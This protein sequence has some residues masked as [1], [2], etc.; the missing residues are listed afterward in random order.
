MK[1]IQTFIIAAFI[2]ALA[3]VPVSRANAATTN[4]PTLDHFK[5][6]AIQQANPVNDFVL[7]QDQFDI[8]DATKEQALVR[9]P[10]F[11]CNPTVK[12][13]RSVTGG[14][15]TTTP[16]T[17]PD[18]HLKMYLMVSEPAGPT[19]AVIVSNQFND[20]QHPQTLAVFRPIILG[21]PTRKLPH[22]PPQ[23]LDH[24]KCYLAQGEPMGKTVALRD[25]F[26][27]RQTEVVSVLS[28]VLFCNPVEKLHDD[29]ITRVENPDGHLV[30]YIFTPSSDKLNV[31]QTINQFGREQLFV[32]RS[33]FLCVPSQKLEFRPIGDTVGGGN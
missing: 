18:A 23:G 27:N 6:Y 8:F 14:P 30:C 33:R 16:I 19:R 25:Q 20:A 29:V 22:A 26:D 4:D 9:F 5:C 28:P 13:T 32:T 31:V 7:L 3:A 10:V 12:I 2:A 17:N 11:F 21:V 24:F 1:S 15:G